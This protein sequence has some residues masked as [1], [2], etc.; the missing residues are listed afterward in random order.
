[1]SNVTE[2]KINTTILAADMTAIKVAIDTVA[3]KIP[4]GT[5]TPDQRSTFLSMDVDNKVFVEDCINEVA[6]S[7]TGIIP[8]FI[9][10]VSLQNDLTLFEQMDIVEANLNNLLQKVKDVKRICADE[11]MSSSNAIYK[12]Y[13]MAAVGGVNGAQQAYDKLK[14]R[15]D[16]Q[17]TSTPAI[18]P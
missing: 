16:R 3:A 11:A 17:R 12:I 9:N 18:T 7:G 5:L 8:A 1:M 6:I 2:N 13:E 4:A 10:S 14:V 15:Y